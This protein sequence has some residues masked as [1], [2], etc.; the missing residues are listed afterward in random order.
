MAVTISPELCIRC[1]GKL[2]CGLKSC[3]LLKKTAVFKDI[4]PFKGKT[5]YAGPSPPAV[6]VSHFSYPKVSVAPLSTPLSFENPALLDD[7]TRWY[8]IPAED[9]VRFRYAL[10]RATDNLD[11]RSASDPP[12]FVQTLHDIALSKKPVDLDVSLSKGLNVSLDLNPISAPLGPKSD[13]RSIQL[14]SNPSTKSIVSKVYY[15][16]DLSATDA[17]TRL[18]NKGVL[19]TKISSLLS[20]GALGVGSKRKLVPTRW[21][22]TAIDDMLSKMLLEDIEQYPLISEYMLFHSR[23][24]ENDF[25]VLLLPSLWSFEHI[26]VWLAGSTWAKGKAVVAADYELGRGRK[27]YASSVTGAYYAARLAVAEYLK[28]KRKQAAAIIFREI[29]PEY[30]IPLGVWQIRENVRHALSS[31]PIIFD[32]LNSVL[33]HLRVRLVTPM[34]TW[35]SHSQL[36]PFF[37]SQTRLFDYF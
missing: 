15:D 17:I 27:T 5:E 8:G 29:H 1:K 28:Y 2:L 25:Y 23:Y 26:E 20:V 33:D 31:N 6:F 24:L 35:L 10:F 18:Y 11:V 30:S 19:E 14:A 13:A 22:I 7:P 12:P 37:K 32:T 34:D 4:E 3:P 9:I 16:T 21:A 36:I